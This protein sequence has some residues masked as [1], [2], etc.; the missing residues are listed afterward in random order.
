MIQIWCWV[1]EENRV[2]RLATFYGVVWFAMLA[3]LTL[4]GFVAWNVFRNQA[5]NTYVQKQLD[6]DSIRVFSNPEKPNLTRGVGSILRTREVNIRVEDRPNSPEQEPESA[7]APR[8]PKPSISIQRPPAVLLHSGN[9]NAQQQQHNPAAAQGQTRPTSVRISASNGRRLR[10]AIYSASVTAPS[11]RPNSVNMDVPRINTSNMRGARKF[12][13]IAV[14]L[15]VVML[16]VWVPSSTNR[17]YSFNHPPKFGLEIAA[18]AVLPL[19]GFFNNLIYCYTSRRQLRIIWRSQ[20]WRLSYKNGV[21]GSLGGRR[22][23]PAER[24]DAEL[25]LRGRRSVAQHRRQELEDL[26]SRYDADDDEESRIGGTSFDAGSPVTSVPPPLPAAVRSGSTKAVTSL[27]NAEQKG[28]GRQ[29][30]QKEEWLPRLSFTD[31]R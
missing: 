8:T 5:S 10:R 13:I 12:A 19:Q 28:Y 11:N 21:A 23:F 29:Q 9:L 20:K 1:T 17:I 18:A 16:I 15:F 22:S 14:A 4:Y 2:L 7:V 31:T 30:R 26:D 27:E 24:G 6:T 3:T 25:P